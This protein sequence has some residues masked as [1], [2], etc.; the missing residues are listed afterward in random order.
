MNDLSNLG[1]RKLR[2][3]LTVLGITIGIWAP[4]PGGG[5]PDRPDHPHAGR[6]I[7]ADQ[8]LVRFA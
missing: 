1:R 8:P 5:G 2:T 6:L 7:E 3:T 4:V